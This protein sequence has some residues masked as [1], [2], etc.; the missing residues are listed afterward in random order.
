MSAP[1]IMNLASASRVV[2][3]FLAAGCDESVTTTHLDAC[4][5]GLP[6]ENG[7]DW[8]SA[9]ACQ[10]AE[11]FGQLICLDRLVANGFRDDAGTRQRTIKLL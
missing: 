9:L 4:P 3:R 10:V 2:N 11:E 7:N 6:M 1:P 5:H 8:R